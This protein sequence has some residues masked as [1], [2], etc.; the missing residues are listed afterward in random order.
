MDLI[1]TSKLYREEFKHWILI[2]ALSIWAITASVFALTNRKETVLIGID[3]V[4]TRI[5][6]SSSDRLIRSEIKNFLT[7]FLNLYYS[8]DE[9]TFS[10]HLGSATELM[11]SDLWDRSKPKLLELNDKLKKL[12]LTQQA[13]ILK[14]DSL[15]PGKV[16]AILALQITS[17]MN[18]QKVKLKVQ[19]EYRKAE[20]TQNN[21]WGFEVTEVSD[22]IQ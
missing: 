19:L 14:I 1:F 17:R 16:E 9:K 22:V 21:P 11:S 5:I 2:L 7:K 8:Y 4:E 20:R 18:T 13:E 6:T 3:D 12:P 15:E 10:E